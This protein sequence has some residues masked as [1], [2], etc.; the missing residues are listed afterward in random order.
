MKHEIFEDLLPISY[1]DTIEATFNNP[2]PWYYTESASGIG[3]NYDIN[4]KNIF[5]SSQF[6]HTIMDEDEPQSNLVELVRPVFW[7]LEQRTG[8]RPRK[9]E[10]I[11]ANLQT[12]NKSKPGNYNPPHVDVTAPTGMS[13][14]YYINDSDGDTVF[15]DKTIDDGYNDL[16]I[17]NR[18]TPKKGRSVLFPSNQFHSSSFPSQGRRMVINFIF[19]I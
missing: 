10:R 13:L 7:F 19:H 6:V 14:L 11:K 1:V 18:V 2:L 12:P 8:L 4:D 9:I 3:A 15:F 5:D 17:A 16:A